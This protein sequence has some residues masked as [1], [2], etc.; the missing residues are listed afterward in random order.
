MEKRHFNLYTDVFADITSKDIGL[1][2]LLQD[3]PDNRMAFEYY[4]AQV[5]LNKDIDNFA[6]NISKLRELGYSRIP[7]Q[8]EEAML[9][10]MK[11][12]GKNIVPVGY[13]ISRETL[14][15]LSGYLEILNTYGSD[16]RKSSQM[17]F[18]EYGGTYW[19]YLNFVNLP[20]ENNASASAKK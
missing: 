4:M 1:M 5:L 9:V 18:R 7:V 19:F 12:T 8:Y 11:H 10:Y 3:H 17:L 6:A 14:S 2:Q 15:R 13:S 16:R 20:D